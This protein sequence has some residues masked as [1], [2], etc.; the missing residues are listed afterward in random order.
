MPQASRGIGAHIEGLGRA[1]HDS[2]IREILMV[3]LS[4]RSEKQGGVRRDPEEFGENQ[5]KEI[6]RCVRSIE[7]KNQVT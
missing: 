5:R 2:E 4:F 1:R 3:R 7:E 6:A